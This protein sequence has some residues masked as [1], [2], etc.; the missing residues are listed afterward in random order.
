MR[1]LST[2][3]VAAVIVAG[4]GLALVLTESHVRLF[5]AQAAAGIMRLTD[6]G[7][8]HAV[9]SAVIFPN[10]QRWIGYTIAASCTAALLIAPFFLIAA[11]LLAT[12][13]VKLRTGLLALI[14]VIVIVGLVNQVRLL[15]I[16]SS[17][18]IWGLQTGY[19][20]S[21]ILA[22]GVVSTFG[23][24]IGIAVFLALMLHERRPGGSTSSSS[25]QTP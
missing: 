3:R 11:G 10:G 19:S 7:Q 21:H 20:R 6:V 12:G 2:S 16:G 13:R 14:A 22:G 23:I 9:G 1:A 5:E 24:I 8:A 15:V 18:R 4:A 25:K 17:M